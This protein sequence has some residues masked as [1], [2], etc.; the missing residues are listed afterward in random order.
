MHYECAFGGAFRAFQWEEECFSVDQSAADCGIPC[1]VH[2][3][4]GYEL[5]EIRHEYFGKELADTYVICSWHSIE[6]ILNEI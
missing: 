4:S 2:V 6:D 5:A 3:F 1:A